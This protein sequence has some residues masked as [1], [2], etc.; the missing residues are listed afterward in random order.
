MKFS[1]IPSLFADA[2]NCM[3]KYVLFDYLPVTGLLAVEAHILS[4]WSI[5]LSSLPSWH[6]IHVSVSSYNNIIQQE[7][8][9]KFH[10][11][12]SL[13]DYSTTSSSPF[14]KVLPFISRTAA[15]AAS[16]S[17]KSIKAY[18]ALSTTCLMRPYFEKLSFKS[19]SLVRLCSLAT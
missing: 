17:S 2:V 10:M 12:F 3:K 1:S 14:T 9:W 7:R 15:T 8:R 18:A 19:A 6:Y 16:W 13:P 4:L 5:V 11:Y